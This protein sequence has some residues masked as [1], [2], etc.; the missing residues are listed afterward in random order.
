MKHHKLFATVAMITLCLFS[1][2]L[3]VSAQTQPENP[4]ELQV[5]QAGGPGMGF[6]NNQGNMGPGGRQAG[7]QQGQQGPRGGQQRGQQRDG[8]GM[9]INW[10]ELDLS[11]EQQA[12]L[13]QLQRDFRVNTA[14]IQEEL[15]YTQQDLRQEMRNE[16]VDQAKID[17]LLNEV[18]S[19]KQKLSE[20]ET[21]NYLAI[22]GILTQ[23]QIEKLAT[24]QQPLPGQLRG[25]DL[26]DEQRAQISTIMKESRE[27]NQAMRQEVRDLRE[28]YQEALFTSGNVDASKLQQLQAD[29]TAKEVAL[30]KEQVNMLLQIRALLTPEQQEQ[31]KQARM[32]Q[33][34]KGKQGKGGRQGRQGGQKGRQRQ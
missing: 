10:R 32:A 26:T 34:Q 24:L 25:V 8:K 9:R 11:E 16:T 18:A 19:L 14:G 29:I 20:A 13:R 2:S 27:K 22:R 7:F 3:L 28:Q 6:G 12:Q 21:Q 31:M 30:E 17:S 4:E 15:R 23:E 33:N 5:A 1:T